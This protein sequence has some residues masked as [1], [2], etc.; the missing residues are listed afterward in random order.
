MK[1]EKLIEEM[2]L[3]DVRVVTDLFCSRCFLYHS[4]GLPSFIYF[5]VPVFY[6]YLVFISNP[7]LILENT[8]ECKEFLFLQWT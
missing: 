5:P 7:H 1:K 3:E 4:F 8:V 2:L 6:L